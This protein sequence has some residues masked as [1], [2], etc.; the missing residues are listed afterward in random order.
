MTAPRYP[1]QST[2]WT[3]IDAWPDKSSLTEHVIIKARSREEGWRGHSQHGYWISPT[4]RA[5]A[6]SASK[7]LDEGWLTNQPPETTK[8][9]RSKK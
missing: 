1:E 7:Y 5:L 4:P 9:K 3:F 2:V 6:G 8:A